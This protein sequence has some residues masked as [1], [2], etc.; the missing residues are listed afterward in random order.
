MNRLSVLKNFYNKSATPI[1]L[2][3]LKV[4][5]KNK[6]NFENILIN[7]SNFLKKELQIRLSH[8][9][10]NL[11]KLPYGLPHVEEIQNITN[12]YID[13][14][15][16][17]LN[18]EN[19]NNIEEVVKFSQ[20]LENIKYKHNDLEINMS[21]GIKK[22]ENYD[23]VDLNILN[24]EL[25]NFF[26]SRIGI[27]TL[28]NHYTSTVNGGQGI[29]KDC[30]INTLICNCIHDVNYISSR[31]YPEEVCDYISISG[32]DSLNINYIPEHI[33]YII[34]EILKNSVIA[35]YC[36]KTE[37]FS[38]INIKFSEGKDYITIKISDKGQSF[39]KSKLKDIFSYS[40]STYP[41]DITNGFE[42]GNLPMIGGLGFGL[43]MSRIYS[44]YF[45]GDL[46]ICPMENEGTDV[47]IYINKLGNNEEVLY[48]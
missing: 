27:R 37:T 42:I 8:R 39:S 16:E 24:K 47:Y 41:V 19:I 15:G 23:L 43:P 26:L 17:I 46:V 4:L 21:Q 32:N 38:N 11:I 1:Q 9:V 40:Y 28:I 13:S 36:E 5:D 48:I 14:F 34:M 10:F 2:N 6:S 30:N 35:S 25:D 22:I 7:Q 31:I 45:N 33:H 29:I 44:K 18:F 12:L 3:M 20:L